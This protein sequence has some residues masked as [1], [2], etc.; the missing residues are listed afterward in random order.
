ME[1]NVAD[2]LQS[3]ALV[4]AAIRSSRDGAV[5]D[6]QDLLADTRESVDIEG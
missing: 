1:T 2:N 3:V 4:E 6:V 5:V